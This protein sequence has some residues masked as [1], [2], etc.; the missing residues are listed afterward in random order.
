MRIL[1][2]VDGRS[3]F[4]RNWISHFISHE[5]EIH[6]ISTSGCEPIPGIASLQILPVAFSGTGVQSVSD[7]SKSASPLTTF[8]R[9]S[10]IWVRTFIRQWLGPLTFPKTIKKLQTMIKIIDPDLVH[11][12]R[13]PYEGI[14]SSL[15]KPA[16][17]L[18]VSVWGNDFTLHAKANPII[19]FYTRKALKITDG[20][21]A[22][23]Q[24]DK[25]LALELG[26]SPEKNTIVLPGNGGIRREVFS[27]PLEPRPL[28]PPVIIN[29]R[30]FRTYIK[31]DTFFHA[32]PKV[33][34]EFPDAKFIC[35]AMEQEVQAQKWVK[36]LGISHAVQLLPLI[37][38]E[39]MVDYYHQSHII[40]SPSTHD[41]TPNT[42]LESMASG[43]F[44]IAGNIESIREWLVDGENSLLFDPTD[45]QTLSDA[46]V[47]AIKNVPLR[48]K[49]MEINQKIIDER[50]EYKIGMGQAENFYQL[51]INE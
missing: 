26:F 40:V 45:V 3:A 51:V 48:E 27:L 2:I 16:A 23:C 24:R 36:Q 13:Y 25:R 18:I 19:G 29:P 43:C 41:G 21:H 15:A 34:E 49:A 31:N 10:P 1:Y 8:R 47:Y 42:L 33:L 6:L 4:A 32:I 7:N 30:G 50:A 11:A 14:I 17:P 44:P 46:I 20:L 37:P 28:S 5:N 38:H 39:R 12:M 35:P 9:I 22:D